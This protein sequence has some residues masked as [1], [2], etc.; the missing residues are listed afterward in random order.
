MTCPAVVR[1]TVPSGPT[2]A[3][4][5]VPSEPAVV[6]VAT[7][8]PPG[9]QGS[10]AP[11]YVVRIDAATTGTIY[12]GRAILGTDGSSTGWTIKRRIFS[13]AGVLAGTGTAAGA[14]SNR[15]NLIY[16]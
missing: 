6:R 9:E 11:Q 2:V 10:A 5:T 13:A 8:G 1:L 14:W 16:T 3:R 4:V 15:A 7:P 12:T